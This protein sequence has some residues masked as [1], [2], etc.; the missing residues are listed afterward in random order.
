MK[1]SPPLHLGLRSG[2]EKRFAVV[3]ASREGEPVQAL[4]QLGS[5]VGVVVA[6]PAAAELDNLCRL[7]I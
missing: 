1:P 6:G 4:A 3:G 2:P 7:V 5:A